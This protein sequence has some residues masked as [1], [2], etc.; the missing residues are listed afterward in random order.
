MIDSTELLNLVKANLAITAC[1]FGLMI[2]FLGVACWS[3]FTA[4]IRYKK[5][6]KKRK[7]E[8]RDEKLKKEIRED[9]IK[10][11]DSTNYND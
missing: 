8:E 7:Q 11:Y 10:Y 6:E 2:I 3:E 1:L 9:I 5:E 4:E